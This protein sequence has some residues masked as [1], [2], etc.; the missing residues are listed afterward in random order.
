MNVWICRLSRLNF[1]CRL[2]ALPYALAHS[3]QHRKRTYVQ[4]TAYLWCRSTFDRSAS[5]ILLQEHRQHYFVAIAGPN[6]L[7]GLVQH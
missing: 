5:F 1:A 4:K 6:T 3:K 2:P 7:V